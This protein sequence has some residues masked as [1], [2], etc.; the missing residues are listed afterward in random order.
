MICRTQR[1]TFL[2]GF[3]NRIPFA[4]KANFNVVEPVQYIL[5]AKENRTFQYIPILKSLKLL[6]SRKDIVDKMVYCYKKQ[7]KAETK[8]EISLCRE[9]REQIIVKRLAHG[10]ASMFN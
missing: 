1:I 6:L 5:D 2:S 4:Q 7:S 3:I 8:E 10:K 9:V